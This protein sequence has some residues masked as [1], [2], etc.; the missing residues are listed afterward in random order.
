MVLNCNGGSAPVMNKVTNGEEAS[1]LLKYGKKLEP[2]KSQVRIG[3]VSCDRKILKC[4]KVL[5]SFCES[6]S[7]V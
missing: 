3:C 7:I 4:K 5:S 1:T 6:R 2:L